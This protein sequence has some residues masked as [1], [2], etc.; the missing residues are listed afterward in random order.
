[1]KRKRV[2]A[3]RVTRLP[4]VYI[5]DLLGAQR[6]ASSKLVTW[7]K[8]DWGIFWGVLKGPLTIAMQEVGS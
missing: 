3:K 7:L 2:D 6:V 5:S 8:E 1:M 4:C